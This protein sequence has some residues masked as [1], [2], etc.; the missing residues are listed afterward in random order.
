MRFRAIKT[1]FQELCYGIPVELIALVIKTMENEILREA[2]KVAHEKNGY[3]GC[4]HCRTR[5]RREAGC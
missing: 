1:Q 5:I 2:V 4:R 3:R